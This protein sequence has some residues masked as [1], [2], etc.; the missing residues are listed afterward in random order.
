MLLDDMANRGLSEETLMMKEVTRKFSNEHVIPFVRQNWKAEWNMVPE[1]RLPRRILEKANE[2][3]IRMSLGAD[4]SRVQRMVLGEGGILVAAGLVLGGLGAV[5]ATRL[6][7]G[8]L[9]GVAPHDPVTL[10]AVNEIEGLTAGM[11]RKIW[12]KITIVDR[13]LPAGAG[14]VQA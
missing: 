1:E 3:G 9:W 13:L 5:F 8:L 7:Q 4:S 14:V 6:M 10:A 11:S 12:Q 2:I